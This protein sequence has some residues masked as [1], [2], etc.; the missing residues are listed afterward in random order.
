MTGNVRTGNVRTGADD[1]SRTRV[2]S[3]H[4]GHVPPRFLCAFGVQWPT[5]AHKN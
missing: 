4:V 2:P 5:I 3:G 1:A